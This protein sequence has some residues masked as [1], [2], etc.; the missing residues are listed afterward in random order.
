MLRGDEEA[1]P[2]SP[3]PGPESLGSLVE[4]VDRAGTPTT[5]TVEGLPEDLPESVA[6][7]VYRIVQEALSNVVRHANGASTRVAV[8]NRDGTVEV[9]VVNAASAPARPRRSRRGPDSGWWACAN[10]SP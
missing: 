1:G 5:L 9:T 3:M 6:L 10:A 7:T 4:S 8:L 2:R